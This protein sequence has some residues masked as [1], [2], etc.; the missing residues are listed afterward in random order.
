MTLGAIHV[1]QVPESGWPLALLTRNP[2]PRAGASGNETRVA[3]VRNPKSKIDNPKSCVG[4]SAILTGSQTQP[5]DWGPNARFGP[6]EDRRN[7]RGLATFTSTL[8]VL[9]IWWLSPFHSEVRR[10]PIVGED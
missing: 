1:S 6:V 4:P 7:H 2:S 9:Q 5:S 3:S 10:R 8:C